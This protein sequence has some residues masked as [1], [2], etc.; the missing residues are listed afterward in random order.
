MPD[1]GWDIAET[2]LQK[3]SRPEEVQE[4]P[5]TNISQTAPTLRALIAIAVLLVTVL[6]LLNSYMKEAPKNTRE[7][8]Q[9]AKSV[10]GRINNTKVIKNVKKTYGEAEQRIMIT[11]RVIN[12]TSHNNH[13]KQPQHN[14]HRLR[15]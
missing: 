6:E 15:K 2:H 13:H 8:A 10:V 7:M 5:E 11:M 3:D 1:L 4:N 12:C 14:T 9:T